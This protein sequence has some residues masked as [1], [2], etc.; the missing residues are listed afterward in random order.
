MT[1]P[2]M[3]SV[4][5]AILRGDG[6]LAGAVVVDGH[7]HIGPWFNFRIPEPYAEGMLRTM[8]HA[9]VH[10][11]WI[12][13]DASIGPDFRLGNAL[14]ADAVERYPD[15]FRGYVTVNPH[16]PDESLDELARRFD[17]GWRLVKFHTGTHQHAADGSGYRPIWEFAQAHRLHLLSHSFPSPERLSR[18][19][20]DYPDV[21]ILVGHAASSPEAVPGLAAVCRERPN[22]YLDLCGSQLWRGLLEQMVTLAGPDRILYGSDIP[23]VDPR[24]QLGRVAFARLPDDTLCRILGGNAR[25]LWDRVA[26]R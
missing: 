4:R 5:D 19:A 8:D 15:R 2:A 21:S 17:Q 14:V 3:S 11:A 7:A 18:L 10:V 24:G 20:A 1:M 16:Y 26:S 9:G 13:A 23:F 12:T 22:V 6:R 25:R